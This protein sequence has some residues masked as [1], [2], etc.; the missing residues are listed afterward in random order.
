MYQDDEA[1][2]Y[3]G[4]DFPSQL[5]PLQCARQELG[6][7]LEGERERLRLVLPIARGMKLPEGCV[8]ID[9][10]GPELP[11]VASLVD[12]WS[13]EVADLQPHELLLALCL[14]AGRLWGP[15]FLGIWWINHFLDP[16]ALR[17]IILP[18]WS[19]AEGPE[20]ALG[21]HNWIILFKTT[22]YVSDGAPPPT[23]PLQV[24]R[25]TREARKVACLGPQTAKRH[26]GSLVGSGGR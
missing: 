26:R 11:S 10:I 17:Q 20:R 15:R 23:A 12:R 22:G 8:V 7:V 4:P 16:Q 1:N 5:T 6:M 21:Q 24:F 19:G 2:R 13:L 18:I 9:E 14:R 3:F 25:G